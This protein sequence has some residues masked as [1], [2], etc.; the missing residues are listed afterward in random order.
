LLNLD[1]LILQQ[2]KDT[3][4]YWIRSQSFNPGWC[5]SSLPINITLNPNEFMKTIAFINSEGK[6]EITRFALYVK[7]IKLT[8]N[9]GV[10][11]VDVKEIEDAKTDNVS[12]KFKDL[13]LFYR[14]CK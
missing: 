8:S 5:G 2:Y 9:S 6:K 7:D 14:T 3:L 12:S 4:G 10:G 13:D 1:L 11:L